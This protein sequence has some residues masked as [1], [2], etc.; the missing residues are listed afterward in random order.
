MS[1]QSRSK[2]ETLSHRQD[3]TFP[4]DMIVLSKGYGVE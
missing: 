3:L 1:L 2:I 4:Y